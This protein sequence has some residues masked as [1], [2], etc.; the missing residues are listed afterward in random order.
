MQERLNLPGRKCLYCVGIQVL[1]SYQSRGVGT[2]L[3]SWVPEL[4]DQSRATCWVHL[5][6]APGGWRMF[7]KMGF[8]MVNANVVDLDAYKT[9]DEDS[10]GNQIKWGTYT[11][12]CMVREPLQHA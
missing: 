12:R 1:P 7:E 11:F 9:K 10:I 5:S 8:R 3:L 2:A 6:D 4:A